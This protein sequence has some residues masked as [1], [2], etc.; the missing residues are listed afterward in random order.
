M[1]EPVRLLV[2]LPNE[3]EVLTLMV[4]KPGRKLLVAS[5]AGDGFVVLE[6]EVVAQTRSGTQVLHLRHATAAVCHSPVAR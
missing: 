3:A 1:G 2:D 5:S 6:D 4:H